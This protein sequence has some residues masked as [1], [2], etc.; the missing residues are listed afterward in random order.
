AF[1]A[2]HDG[3]E[4]ELTISRSIEDE[5]SPS[6][7]AGNFPDLVVLGQGRAAGLTE[8]LIADEALE[9]VSDVLSMTVPGEDVTVEEKIIDGVVGSLGTNP[10]GDDR[11][12]LLPL[13]YAPTGLVY[14]QGLFAEQGWEVPLTW[15][16]MFALGDEIGRAHV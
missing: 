13:N 4:V 11:T 6:M 9:E 14:D 3:V 2:E 15:D 10:Y 5:I 12:F 1:E 16:D 7:Q 8:A